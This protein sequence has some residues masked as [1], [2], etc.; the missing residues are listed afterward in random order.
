MLTKRK[1]HHL[2]NEMLV[3]N[4]LANFIGVFAVN[5]L[6]YLGEGFTNKKLWDYAVPFWID[7]FFSPFA[8]TFVCVMTLLYERPIR[9]YLT[10]IYK[11]APIP[12]DLANT[13]RQ[14]LLNEPFVL[15]SY[16]FS[17]WL[18]SAIVYPILHWIY[19][20]GSTMIQSSLYHGLHYQE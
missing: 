4:F 8:F 16:D 15:I 20:S 5:A 6:M 9:R 17:M 14:K 2:K 11:Q 3:A 10:S 18:L 7:T 12:A 19:N 13:A 1:L